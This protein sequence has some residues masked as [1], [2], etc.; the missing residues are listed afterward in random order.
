MIKFD[1]ILML[2]IIFKSIPILYACVLFF[3]KNNQPKKPLNWIKYGFYVFQAFSRWLKVH[4]QY[5][6]NN[7]ML[8]L[9]IIVFIK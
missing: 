8:I 4:N 9:F 5:F 1:I 7:M 3:Y 6:L 2:F